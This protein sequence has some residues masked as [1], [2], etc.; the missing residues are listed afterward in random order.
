MR[1]PPAGERE[2]PYYIAAL[3]QKE[4]IMS[5]LMNLIIPDETCAFMSEEGLYPKMHQDVMPY[6]YRYVHNM[7]I[8]EAVKR[9]I[10]E[11]RYKMAKGQHLVPDVLRYPHGAPSDIIIKKVFS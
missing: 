7:D 9:P 11:I 6:N 3:R 4:D 5:N 10:K 2:N 1:Y 8:N